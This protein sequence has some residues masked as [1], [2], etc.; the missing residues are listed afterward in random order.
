MENQETSLSE[1]GLYGLIQHINKKISS[2][3][4][5]N[6]DNYIEDAFLYKSKEEQLLS[7]TL[8][9]EGIHFDLIYTPLQHLGFKL[10][11][12][13]VTDILA[14]NCLPK[15]ISIAVGLSKKM[16]LERTDLL[17]DGV[18]SACSKYGVELIGF[19]PYPSLT[20]LT[21]S[22]SIIGDADKDSVVN[23][24]KAKPT[25]ILL[26]SGDLGASLLGLHLLEREKRVLQDVDTAKP[27]LSGNEYVL[28]RQLKPEARVEVIERLS[29]KNIIPTSMISIKE[30]L[31]NATIL[32]SNAS[33]IGS[34]IY[35]NKIPLHQETLRIAKEMDFNPLIAALNGGE[36]FEL[37][38][39]I[40]LND[41]QANESFISTF[42][43]AIGYVTEKEYSNRII[44]LS[45]DEI[46]I[47]AQGWGEK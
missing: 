1:I 5:M 33:D 35:E 36:D 22:A 21:L 18:Q 26:C 10:V 27:E 8:M 4:K 30:G 47:K 44:S 17:L 45:G 9:L 32:L 34:R 42:A 38:F 43:T 19:K 2:Q 37:L 23:R 25:D 46:D 3:S 24:S 13:A 29:E 12:N 31:A 39:T 15:R 20:G 41:F 28:Q 16:T 11:V 7:Q 14:M 6:L 40:S